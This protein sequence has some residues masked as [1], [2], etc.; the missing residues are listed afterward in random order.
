MNYY[1]RK[2]KIKSPKDIWKTDHFCMHFDT[3]IEWHSH[4]TQIFE[5]SMHSA[6]TLHFT[7][8][9]FPNTQHLREKCKVQPLHSLEYFLSPSTHIK[10]IPKF[11]KI[12]Y[13]FCSWKDGLAFCGLIHR[14]RPELIPNW[15][16]LRRVS[17]L[18]NYFD[19]GKSW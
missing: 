12:K 15:N 2:C 17:F 4:F 18:I 16:E 9:S 6:L 5:K 14:H 19:I 11:S 3:F 10:N 13:S 8:A 1:W 7:Y